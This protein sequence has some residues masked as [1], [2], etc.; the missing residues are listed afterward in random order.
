MAAGQAVPPLAAG[1]V[2]VYVWLPVPQLAEQ[3]PQEPTQA[4]GVG[5]GL[6]VIGLKAKAIV[7]ELVTA[8]FQEVVPVPK[9]VV[10][11][12][13]ISTVAVYPLFGVTVNVSVAP[14]TMLT[15]PELVIAAAHEGVTVPVPLG[16]TVTVS[17]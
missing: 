14:E 10:G 17:V 6:V 15:V 5:A 3:G 12:E 4:T 11:P 13:P 16:L 2:I 7:S 1:V 9:A 8:V